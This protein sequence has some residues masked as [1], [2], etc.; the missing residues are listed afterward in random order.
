[1][2]ISSISHSLSIISITRCTKT[3]VLP[4]PAAA[5]TAAPIDT[6]NSGTYSAGGVSSAVI[7]QKIVDNDDG[8]LLGHLR[9][10]VK[11]QLY[12]E[13]RTNLINGLDSDAVVVSVTP[14]WRI[15]LT[16]VNICL[17]V[18]TAGFLGL[19]AWS[20]VRERKMRK[21]NAV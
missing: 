10:A 20:V 6:G 9:R 8:Y 5:E 4:E 18:L 13:S 15:A 16:A 17:G 3:A 14:G 7:L 1:M 11:N 12:A 21:E 19:Y 2:S